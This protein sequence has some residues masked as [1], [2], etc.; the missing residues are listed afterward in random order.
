M[1]NIRYNPDFLSKD[2]ADSF[3]SLLI[4]SIAWKQNYINIYGKEVKEPRLTAWYGDKE[5]SYSGITN[6]PLP[7]SEY[8]DNIRILLN[9]RTGLSFNSCLCNLYR[10][11]ND[12][13]GYHSDNE[14]ELGDSPIIASI[15]LG[16]ERTINFID[17]SKD[18]IHNFKMKHGSLL[19]MQNDCQSL[20]KHGI[21]KN[22]STHP[23][24]NLT[25][26]NIQ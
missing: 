5:Y 13:I 9:K 6:T 3:F 4:N 7:F 17:K 20:Y 10:N 12:S 21:L 23:R 15:S 2:E 26:R 24:I 25:F 16:D 18:I 8:L 14:K 19:I 22:N 11:G 1:K